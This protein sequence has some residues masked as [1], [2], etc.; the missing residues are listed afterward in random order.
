MRDFPINGLLSA[1]SLTELIEPLQQIFKHLKKFKQ[2]N[3]YPLERLFQ[4][5]EAI[6]RDLNKQLHS[7]LRT[8]RLMTIDFDEF[9]SILSNCQKIHRVWED[10]SRDF[11]DMIRSL[12]KRKTIISVF[13]P[14]LQCAH[15]VLLNRIESIRSVRSQH[16]KLKDVVNGLMRHEHWCD[17]HYTRAIT[18][19][20]TVFQDIDALD[21]SPIGCE[22]FEEA[23]KKYLDK[24]DKVETEI[25]NT[26]RE[27]LGATKTGM[28][29][30]RVFSQYNPLFFRP[31]IQ[32]AIQQYQS[33]LIKQVNEEVKRLRIQFS[34]TYESSSSAIISNVL[35]I[36]NICGKF[37]WYK[38]LERKLKECLQRMED[39]L[40]KSWE[41]H[42]DGRNLKLIGN[43]FLKKLNSQ[44][45]FDQW[46]S[47]IRDIKDCDYQSKIVFNIRKLNM[48]EYT[49]VL[50]YDPTIMF[51]FKEARH[52]T[53]LGIHVPYS[54][55][56]SAQ[57]FQ[58]IYPYLI[59]LEECCN[60]FMF[61][62]RRLQLHTSEFLSQLVA[63]YQLEVYDLLNE[64]FTIT[65]GSENLGVFTTSLSEKVY[66]FEEKLEELEAYVQKIK[67]IIASL[68]T[69]SFDNNAV[70]FSKVS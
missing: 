62:C 57:D 43:D 49:I 63:H 36:P 48:N 50:N 56:F 37:I 41:Q 46:I 20:Y 32:D 38:Q 28:E 55:K 34:N 66:T 12:M 24:I 13:H 67:D 64:G 31:R 27:R 9:E 19:A 7:I 69:A 6:S 47:E 42:A 54:V 21:T 4:F 45:I 58:W 18:S 40:G 61:T 60:T 11:K 65:W 26:L 17:S 33:K 22:T 25:S 1:R 2:V 51:Y 39:V 10:G 68:T 8:Q 70:L 44:N 15:T 52:F 59:K 53:N 3:H 14:K 29:M 5:V 16:Q 35:D 30:F 23:K